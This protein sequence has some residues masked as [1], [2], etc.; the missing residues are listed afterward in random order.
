M[1]SRNRG[2][3]TEII[4]PSGDVIS[5]RSRLESRVCDDLTLRQVPWIYEPEAFKYTLVHTYTPDLLLSGS[6]GKIYVE[7]KGWFQAPDRTKALHVR[8]A[9][10]NLD[11]RFLFQSAERT[12]NSSSR[13]TYAAWCKKNDFLFCEARVPESWLK[14]IEILQ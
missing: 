7:V 13:T 11:L 1:T 12:L 4:D 5:V 8:E 3:R 14:E 10:P 6:A 9:N 2:S